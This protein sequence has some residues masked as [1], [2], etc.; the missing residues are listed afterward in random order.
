MS[1][2]RKGVKFE[3]SLS[4]LVA[5]YA[6][7]APG[8][9]RFVRKKPKASKPKV[10]KPKGVSKK[11]S[12]SKKKVVFAD[13]PPKHKAS[14][15][16][17]ASLRRLEK[18][19]KKAKKPKKSKKEPQ[20]SLFPLNV[21]EQR[22]NYRGPPPTLPPRTYEE[23]DLVLPDIA[24]E[25]EEYQE[26]N[27][28]PFAFSAELPDKPVLPPRRRNTASAYP[29]GSRSSFGRFKGVRTGENRRERNRQEREKNDDT[30]VN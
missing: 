26:R 23:E 22:E 25:E 7:G 18:R 29:R 24:P 11:K 6:V 14:Y 1:Q 9:E 17:F 30:T 12:K 16:K 20:G 21:V 28:E 27:F 8:T 2:R 19:Q 15:G 10:S 3:S 4:R 13:L 5:A